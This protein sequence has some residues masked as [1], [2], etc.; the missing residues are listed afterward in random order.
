M[1]EQIALISSFDESGVSL[2]SAGDYFRGGHDQPSAIVLLGGF[3]L[4]VTSALSYEF[5]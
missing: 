2:L 5:L 3:P 4:S 1:R